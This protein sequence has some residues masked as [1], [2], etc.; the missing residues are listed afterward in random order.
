[1]TIGAFRIGQL[2]SFQLEKTTMQANCSL[3]FL[4]CIA[5]RLLLSV[6]SLIDDADAVIVLGSPLFVVKGNERRTP[7]PPVLP[8]LDCH[9]RTM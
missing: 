3:P 2:L 6:V 1:V 7:V 4:R 9:A 5:D 8:S